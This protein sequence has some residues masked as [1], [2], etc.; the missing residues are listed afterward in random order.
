MTNNKKIY[1]GFIVL[2]IL[3]FAIL[4]FGAHRTEAPSVS[5]PAVSE[6]VQ[7]PVPEQA[8][9]PAKNEPVSAPEVS[10]AFNVTAGTATLSL[11]T[12]GGS[13]LSILSAAKERGE[14][15]F[16][17]K[18]YP[19]LGF[20]VTEIGS[21]KEGNGKHLMYYINGTEASVGVSL[22]VPKAGDTVVWEL[23]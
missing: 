13:F 19:G 7:S 9:P 23:K 21:L 2:A 18:D 8:V 12:T 17:G 22:Y 16:S 6:Q 20:F 3:I 15:A 14:L 1:S 4:Y 5:V 11:S 10:S